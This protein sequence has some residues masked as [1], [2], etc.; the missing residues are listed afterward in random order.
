MLTQIQGCRSPV[1]KSKRE[2]SVSWWDDL[3]VVPRDEHYLVFS[4]SRRL[5]FLASSGAVTAL[6]RVREDPTA[7]DEPALSTLLERV[8]EVLRAEPRFL[9][10]R[11]VRSEN[12]RFQPTTAVLLPTM[13]CSLRCTYCFSCAGDVS[14]SMPWSLAS[15]TVDFV[16]NNAHTTGHGAHFLFHG[17]GEP[18][19]AWQI[20]T[21]VVDRARFTGSRLGVPVTFGIVTNGLF[22]LARCEW[23][24]LNI[25]KITV[26]LDGHPD[27]QDFQRPT[28]GGGKSSHAVES[29]CAHFRARGV[30]FSI[31]ATVTEHSLEQ[32]E[33]VTTYLL[34]LQPQSI[35]IEPL[36]STGR[37]AA[38][39]LSGPSPPRFVDLFKRCREL[40]EQSN[41]ELYTSGT[42]LNRCSTKACGAAGSTFC[43]TPE[44]WI[45]SCHRVSNPLDPAATE[46][47]YGRFD[48]EMQQFQIDPVRL[49]KLS[50]LSVEDAP[51]CSGCVARWHCSG[52]CYQENYAVR[53]ELLLTEN[54][55]HCEIKHGLNAYLLGQ[56]KLKST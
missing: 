43:V 56:G 6:R 20:L 32:L 35:Q 30:K 21:G 26:S 48:A 24:A 2:S 37:A 28:K 18:T 47:F 14:T 50:S 33:E 46:F 17:G 41:I 36:T 49:R 3:V 38:Q 23:L 44:G 8:S 29:T 4:P 31:R 53:R 27:V 52:G 16:L 39:A 54:I 45:T 13:D 55:D 34:S 9:P 25:N 15:S 19:L 40:A 7:E 5:G 51:A 10:R 12:L 11:S 1:P 42:R 22:S